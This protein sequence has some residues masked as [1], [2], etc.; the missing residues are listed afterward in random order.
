M[1]KNKEGSVE[2][3]V[4]ELLDTPFWLTT[5][6]TDTTYFRTHDDCDG[7]L[8]QGIGVAIDQQGDVWIGMGNE[9]RRFRT[10]GGGG[11]SLR[12]RNALLVLAE[13]IRQD[14]ESRPQEKIK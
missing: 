9:S 12:V 3:I 7:D 13:A 8:S 6:K 10:Y 5:L 11:M 2:P 4:K 1:K 14:N